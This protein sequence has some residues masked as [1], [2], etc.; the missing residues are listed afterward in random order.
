MAKRLSHQR[1]PQRRMLPYTELIQR[2]SGKGAAYSNGPVEFLTWKNPEEPPAWSVRVG[3][4]PHM[5]KSKKAEG[6]SM[7][8]PRMGVTSSIVVKAGAYPRREQR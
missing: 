7:R 4:R 6:E 8:M 1:Q 5:N 3:G 2:I